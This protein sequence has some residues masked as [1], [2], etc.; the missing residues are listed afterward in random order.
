MKKD[1]KNT[2]TP[3]NLFQLEKILGLKF[4]NINLF[5]QA[6]THRSYLNECKNWTYGQNERLEF[7]GDAV[8]ELITTEYLYFT[9]ELPEGQLTHLRASL[10][11]TKSLAEL[12]QKLHFDKFLYLSKGERATFPRGRQHILANTLEAF[13]GAL[14]LDQGIEVAK[15][16]LSK[17]L[18]KK[19][20]FILKNELYKD[21]KSTFQEIAQN[22]FGITPTYKLVE[23]SGPSHA[24][25]FTI[26][27]MLGDKIIA[28][29]KGKSKQEAQTVAASLALSRW[30]QSPNKI[31]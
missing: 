15:K 10:V 13:I 1:K 11:N 30:K 17:H 20:N 3:K 31:C 19:A 2:T 18:L 22:R 7:L 5:Q 14:Y 8:L 26:N 25:I 23:E 9:F 21:A 29:G 12:A 24:K 4:K 16:F 28:Q 27:L 6:F